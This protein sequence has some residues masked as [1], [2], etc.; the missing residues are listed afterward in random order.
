[1]TNNQL[2]ESETHFRSLID[3]MLNGFAYCR[4]HFENGQP[5]D[6]TYIDVN[7]AFE[8]LT[9]LKDVVG[10]RVSEVIPGMLESNPEL[11]ETYGRVASSG[12]PEKFET[13]V[14]ELDIWFSVSVYCPESEHFVAIFDNISERKLHE[15]HSK[16]IHDLMLAI[17]LINEHLLV[18]K[19]ENELFDF[20]CSTLKG[21]E[22]VDKVW[23][24]LGNAG[25]EVTPVSV[26]GVDQEYLQS[27]PTRWDEAKNGHGPMQTAIQERKA[28]IYNDAPNDKNLAWCHEI[29]DL[30]IK[31]GASIPLANN[32]DVM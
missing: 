1:M 4:M 29:E 24:G 9:G 26:A 10:K 2:Q 25:S 13:Y 8:K 21:L 22:I 20:I 14:P 23:I 3:H 18:T 16:Q 17:R 30:H 27:L 31:S 6:F 15:I 12:K 28:I 32:G 19:N 7:P 5:R 11:F